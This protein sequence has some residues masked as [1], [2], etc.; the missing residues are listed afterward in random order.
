MI[1][2][3]A[4]NQT[5]LVLNLS[6]S[7][8]FVLYLF[9]NLTLS[10]SVLI[11]KWIK[12]GNTDTKIEATS[13]IDQSSR[14]LLFFVCFESHAAIQ[15]AKHAPYQP[16]CCSYSYFE[17]NCH[18]SLVCLYYLSRFFSISCLHA[19]F[20]VYFWN[21]IFVLSTF[22]LIRLEYWPWFYVPPS[23]FLAF[24]VCLSVCVSLCLFVSVL[25]TKR[26]N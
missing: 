18:Q 21:V 2:L 8:S 14:G 7:I 25:V 15:I 10:I 16:F 6:K 5:G 19:V 22:Q 24:S 23:H 3:S 4:V 12:F 26:L 9:K 17:S 11:N 1:I 13:K 20:L